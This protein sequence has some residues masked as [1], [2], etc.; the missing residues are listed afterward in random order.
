M[1]VHLHLPAEGL[2]HIHHD[3]LDISSQAFR[4]LCMSKT[5][6][7]PIYIKSLLPHDLPASARPCHLPELTLLTLEGP[8]LSLPSS[9]TPDSLSG[10]A[11]LSICSAAFLLPPPQ[12]K[13]VFLWVRNSN[14]R[15]CTSHS[16]VPSALIQPANG[17]LP[18]TQSFHCSSPS[19]K[20]RPLILPF[21]LLYWIFGVDWQE[22]SSLHIASHTHLFWQSIALLQFPDFFIDNSSRNCQPSRDCPIFLPLYLLSSSSLLP[23]FPFPTHICTHALHTYAKELPL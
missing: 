20:W 6:L 8:S 11:F 21:R 14:S 12:C 13:P 19:I 1:Y 3:R 18:G 16:R 5:K 10:C 9:L 23:S 22:N 15:P 2:T 7:I 17:T 4:R